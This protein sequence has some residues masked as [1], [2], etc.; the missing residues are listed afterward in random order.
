MGTSE[1]FNNKSVC[2]KLLAL[3]L[4]CI[5]KHN[6]IQVFFLFISHGESHRCYKDPKCNFWILRIHLPTKLKHDFN[7]TCNSQQME[8]KMQKPTFFFKEIGSLHISNFQSFNLN[9]NFCTSVWANIRVKD[10]LVSVQQI[11]V[12]SHYS[13]KMTKLIKANTVS[14][15]SHSIQWV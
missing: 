11:P 5:F 2:L 14:T 6:N 12:S 3:P 10:G 9:T 15:L 13:S 1:S 7:Q 4:Q 8:S